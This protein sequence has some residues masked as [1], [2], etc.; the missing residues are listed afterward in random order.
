MN[1]CE[2]A[3][4]MAE[5]K[6]LNLILQIEKMELKVLVLS[7]VER[8]VVV[9]WKWGSCF[10]EVGCDVKSELLQWKWM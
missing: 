2:N 8:V 9:Q 4:A 7:L 10:T 6:Q 5:S 3:D 1:V